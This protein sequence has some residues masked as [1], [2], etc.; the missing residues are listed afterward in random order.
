MLNP[1]TRPYNLSMS[2][3]ETEPPTG[4]RRIGRP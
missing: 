3:P 2:L 1:E 4:G